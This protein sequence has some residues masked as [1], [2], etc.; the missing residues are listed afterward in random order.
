VWL[1]NSR[2]VYL[3][4]SDVNRPFR[5]VTAAFFQAATA[6]VA[7]VRDIGCTDAHGALV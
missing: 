4:G 3:A 2:N 7:G 6:Q 5:I 1:K